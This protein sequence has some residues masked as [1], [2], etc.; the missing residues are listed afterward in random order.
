MA[1][2]EKSLGLPAGFIVGLKNEDDWSFVIK[3]HALL[4][5][6]VSHL[7]AHTLGKPALTQVFSR[8]DMASAFG[9]L[10]FA[11]TLGVVE[12]RTRRFIRALGEIRNDFVHDVSNAGRSLA[13][14]L[15][16]LEKQQ[17][18]SKHESLD[19]VFAGETTIPAP[20]GKTVTA[21]AIFQDY[22]KTVLA[23]SLGL[24]LYELHMG[25]LSA[26]IAQLKRARADEMFRE[27]AFSDV[28]RASLLDLLRQSGSEDRR[29][30]AEQGPPEGVT[31]DANDSH[32]D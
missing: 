7:L 17:L 27:Y 26:Q 14:Y 10:A 5:A 13:D 19:W 21:L 12:K 1:E 18:K 31:E 2:F 25:T 32:H 9:K 22:P 23:A 29:P 4:E 16:Q 20:G 30:E 8:L 3:A 28:H 6:G 24:V 15:S 11:E